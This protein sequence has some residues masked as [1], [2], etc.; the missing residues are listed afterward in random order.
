[1]FGFGR[2]TCGI[3]QTGDRRL[4]LLLLAGL[5]AAGMTTPATGQIVLP[6]TPLTADQ[7]IVDL[8]EYFERVVAVDTDRDRVLVSGEDGI[9][10]VS[11]QGPEESIEGIGAIRSM[12][13]TDVDQVL[14]LGWAGQLVVLDAATLEQESTIDLP[15]DVSFSDMVTAGDRLFVAGRTEQA[16]TLWAADLEALLSGDAELQE[17]AGPE[18]LGPTGLAPILLPLSEPDRVYIVDTS[19]VTTLDV[20]EA[21]VELVGRAEG[22]GLQGD[23]AVDPDEQVVY[24][25]GGAVFD[26]ARLT[27]SE[28]QRF[29]SGVSAE[30]GLELFIASR[31]SDPVVLSRLAVASGETP[32]HLRVR[33]PGSRVLALDRLAGDRLVIT[34]PESVCITDPPV[35]SADLSDRRA[36]TTERIAVGDPT[37]FAIEVSRLRFPDQ[38][39][40]QP[41]MVV[42]ARGD[43]FADAM[44]GTSLTADAPLLYV[45]DDGTIP[46]RVMDEIDRVLRNDPLDAERPLIVLLGG[47]EAIKRVEPMLFDFGYQTRRLQ[48]RDRIETAVAIAQFVNRPYQ[49]FLARAYG[50]DADATSAWA[51]AVA[52]GTLTAQVQP[53][54]LTTSDT[55]HPAV[56]Q[57]LFTNEPGIRAVRPIGGDVALAG[58]IDGQLT[59]L[60]ITQVGPRFRGPNRAGTAASIFQELQRGSQSGRSPVLAFNGY[61]EEGWAYALVGAGL[62]GDLQGALLP[63]GDTLP[64]ETEEAIGCSA[65]TE[66]FLL[67]GAEQ[68]SSD[69]AFELDSITAEC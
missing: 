12:L 59:E 42:L 21:D 37:D 30:S 53:V 24:F 68:I 51:D 16:S 33:C 7:A 41:E 46:P 8:P 34:T 1:M 11:G 13:V 18:L 62:A 57:Y 23:V 63:V 17:V 26:T 56:Q 25:G 29:S 28:G 55:L 15:A 3:A 35:I 27:V 40:R 66:L 48:G 6:P 14:A 45:G 43:V 44:A 69:V 65:T 39:P 32:V 58:A 50:T 67:G 4:A 64:P 54:L 49:H 61:V 2:L 22:S 19:S 5:I 38:G 47:P 10:A 20:T 9:V 31:A 60:G 52:I 36:D